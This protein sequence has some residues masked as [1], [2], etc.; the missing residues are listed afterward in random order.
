MKANELRIGSYFVDYE[1]D[2]NSN[3][4]FQVEE[5]SSK[6]VYF[7]NCSSWTIFDDLQPIPLTEE[8][9][10]KCGFKEFGEDFKLG[11]YT[12]NLTLKTLC[13]GLQAG[14]NVINDVD[15]VNLHQ[16]QNLYFALTGEELDIKL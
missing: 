14:C 3:I 2:P 12:F 15:I 13:W 10:L 9:L 16:L 5:I 11:E 6:G 8:I 4:Y 7:R 1:A